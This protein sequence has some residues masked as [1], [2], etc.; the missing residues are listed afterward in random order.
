MVSIDADSEYWH[1]DIQC[2]G[3][4]GSADLGILAKF[5][6]SIG[7]LQGARQHLQEL[8]ESGGSENLFKCSSCMSPSSMQGHLKG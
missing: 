2:L 1:S 5:P 6:K 7:L 3:K 8:G 4:Q